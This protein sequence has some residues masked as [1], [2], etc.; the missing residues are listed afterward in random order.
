M[1]LPAN[2][3]TMSLERLRILNAACERRLKE[4]IDR[5]SRSNIRFARLLDEA[6]RVEDEISRREAA[7]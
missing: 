2:L 6:L 7:L 4:E 5:V 1:T 3:A